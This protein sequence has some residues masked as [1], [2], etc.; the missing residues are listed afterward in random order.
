MGDAEAVAGLFNACSRETLGKPGISAAELRTDWQ[1]PGFDLHDDTQ[2]VWTPE[3]RLVG[4]GDLWG[5][6]SSSVRLMPWVRVH[7]GYR[8]HGIG[9]YLNGWAE[10]RA[11]QEIVKAPEG[12]RIVLETFAPAA[13]RAARELLLD[14][15]MTET[16]HSYEMEIELDRQP[17]EPEWPEGISVRRR[18]PGDERAFY[19]VENEAFRDHY[20]HVEE[21]FEE[22]FPKWKHLRENEPYYDPSLWFMAEE[23]GGVAG[24]VICSPQ[25]TEDPGMGWVWS[26]A[27]LR[28][29]RK[30]GIGLALLLHCFGE[31]FRR[32][33]PRAGLSVDAESLTDA[34][35]LY[36][37]AGMRVTHKHIR[38]EKELRPGRDLSTRSV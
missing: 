9:T 4:Y 31:L 23:R 7:P 3:G 28:R 19:E 5:K 30:H 6:S 32:G 11:R 25:T 33:I 1:V 15:G 27:V 20:G 22:D 38:L 37:K 10:A 16:R 8:D 12:A 17:P 35:R 21:P 13:D 29:W 36:E 34:T 24:L 14:L 18:S 2:A 26:L